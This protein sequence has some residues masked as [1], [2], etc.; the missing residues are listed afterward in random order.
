MLDREQLR[1]KMIESATEINRLQQRIH[2]SF[3]RRDESEELRR[4]WSEA[5]ARFHATYGEL[6]LPAGPEQNFYERLLAGDEDTVEIAL[7]FLEVR[8]YFFRSGYIWKDMLRKIKRAPLK[9][10]Q[11]DRLAVLL[12]RYAEWRELR[13][14]SSKRGAE[15][16]NALW[17]LIQ[18][19]YD[20]F[21]TK[22]A[23]HRYDGIAT[24]G[25]LYSVICEAMKVPPLDHPD[26][27][28]GVAR[29]PYLM[30]FPKDNVAGWA[31]GYQEWR[32]SV[33]KP[34]DI[35]ATLV[36]TIVDVYKLDN[37]I[38]IVPETILREPAVNDPSKT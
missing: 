18:R 3:K 13:K 10:E 33:W 14:Q 27:A 25:D 28:F 30:R 20:L 2:E 8:P 5:C 38:E 17:P 19:F 31:K 11:A 6:C 22:I 9:G 7:C 37:S 23:D 21:P 1:A 26:R 24:V 16:R 4:Q 29:R 15:I 12:K 35:W 32:H 36:S 34:E